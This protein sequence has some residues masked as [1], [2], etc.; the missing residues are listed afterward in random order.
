MRKPLIA[1]SLLLSILAAGLL[2]EDGGHRH[3]GGSGGRGG[4]REHEH[5]DDDNEHG[6][7]GEGG[8][9]GRSST[10]NAGASGAGGMSITAVMKQ[11]M[12]GDNSLLKRAI[13]GS[14]TDAEKTKL[15]DYIKKLQNTH[16]PAGNQADWDNRIKSLVTAATDLAANKQGAV[17]ALKTASNCK[18]CHNAHQGN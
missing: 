15:L 14:A 16:P 17:D 4:E 9:G 7:G 18:S 5:G 1:A 13:N 8:P 6:G 10:S 11:S 3:R 2:A 12:K